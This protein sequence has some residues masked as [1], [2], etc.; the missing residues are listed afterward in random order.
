M[1]TKQK[2]L[3]IARNL[4][5][6]VVLLGLFYLFTGCPD[7]MVE[8]AYRRAEKRNL[9]GPGD[10]LAVLKVDINGGYN[11]LLLAETGKGVL[12]YCYRAENLGYI[13]GNTFSSYEG[14]LVYR[15]KQ[16]AVS[17]MAA[18]GLHYEYGP[19]PK[20][21]PLILFD[22]VPKAVRAEIEF[23]TT[24]SVVGTT[25]D[26]DAP[27]Y[28]FSYR[29]EAER[30]YGGLF[31][32]ELTTDGTDAENL[33]VARVSDLYTH[34][35]DRSSRIPVTVRLYDQKDTLIYEGTVHLEN[36]RAAAG[37]RLGEIP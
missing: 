7:M 22:E 3:R 20:T 9:V 1:S 25:G 32:F 10:I 6:S 30:E 26:F 5:L 31:V 13:Q 29:L 11:R 37:V 12:Q 14:D 21:L 35:V 27:T 2:I 15:E 17:I 24:G 18:T 8:Q 33:A 34:R 19:D 36:D 4:L 16:G 23:Q 28:D